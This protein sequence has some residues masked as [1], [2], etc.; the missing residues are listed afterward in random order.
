MY[1]THHAISYSF[2]VV[3][4]VSEWEHE[5]KLYCGED[6]AEFFL[7]ALHNI[8]KIIYENTFPDLSSEEREEILY[9]NICHICKEEIKDGEKKVIDHCHI[10]GHVRSVAHN[11]C[12]LNYRIDPKR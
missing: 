4:S 11:K 3:L 8:A 6:A 7:L 10:E 9:V 2:K 12:N 1:Q 5:V